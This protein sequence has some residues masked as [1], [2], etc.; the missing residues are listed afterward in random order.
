MLGIEGTG[1][2]PV[3]LPLPECR[4]ENTDGLA[5]PVNG[6]L[7]AEALKQGFLHLR[8]ASAY[9]PLV[10]DDGAEGLHLLMPLRGEASS[11]LLKAAGIQPSQQLAEP[12]AEPEPQPIAPANIPSEPEEPAMPD[13]PV[14]AP[15][16]KP[17]APVAAP[18]RNLEMVPTDDPIARLEELANES[19]EQLQQALA[20][21]RELKR[22]VRAAKT[23]LRAREKEIEARERE[24]EKSRG[25]IQ[26]LQE[27]IAA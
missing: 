15:Q 21:V 18:T 7:L 23:H 4:C 2:E 24:M 11:V 19:Q 22:Q 1:G 12:A 27:A 16:P 26:R 3:V 5:V 13:T 17:V 14:P 20:T 10:F 9:T 8:A 6:V 25:L